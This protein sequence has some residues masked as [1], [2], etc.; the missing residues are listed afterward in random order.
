M[1]DLEFKKKWEFLNQY[2][3]SSLNLMVRESNLF[4]LL[5]TRSGFFKRNDPPNPQSPGKLKNAKSNRTLVTLKEE[6][7][8]DNRDKDNND[9]SKDKSPTKTI[10]APKSVR[11]NA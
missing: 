7:K 6:K 3:G 11:M 2:A 4:E 8:D 10:K 9:N 5:L 1:N